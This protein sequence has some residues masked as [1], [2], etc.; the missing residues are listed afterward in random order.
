M[1]VVAGRRWAAVGVASVLAGCLLA[2][3]AAHTAPDDGAPPTPT[4]P[5]PVV[6]SVP[7]PS[8]AAAPRGVAELADAAWVSRMAAAAGIPERALAAYAG[9]TLRMA[10]DAPGC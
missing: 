1:R 7:L 5:S 2:G 8:A 3:C 10:Q 4:F 6:E 9:A